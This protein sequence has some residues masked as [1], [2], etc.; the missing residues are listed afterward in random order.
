[1]I[2]DGYKLNSSFQR[3]TRFDLEEKIMAAWH[4][5]DDLKALYNNVEEM[6][7]DQ[8]YGAI[9]GLRIF[10]DMRQQE[11]WDTYE[12]M[13]HNE[14]LEAKAKENISQTI[15]GSRYEETGQGYQVLP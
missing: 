4:T 6:D 1:M 15:E 11:L 13:L 2:G 3:I 10:A 7:L 8:L 14:R 12:A 9:D 5:V